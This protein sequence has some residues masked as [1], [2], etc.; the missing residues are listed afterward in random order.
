MRRHLIIFVCLIFY[1]IGLPSA[2]YAD[3]ANPPKIQKVTQ[4]TKGPYSPG[5]MI[6]FSIEVSGGNPGLTTIRIS[7]DCF[8][9]AWF[10]DPKDSYQIGSQG[11][12]D[13]S[14]INEKLITGRIGGCRSKTYTAS[15]TV[16]DKT[17]L[18]DGLSFRSNDLNFEIKNRFL[19]AVGEIQPDPDFMKLQ[20]QDDVSWAPYVN[21]G[22]E[23]TR[24]NNI[25]VSKVSEL[26]IL[27]GFSKLGQPIDWWVQQEINTN[28]QII[29]RFE[30]DVG[31]LKFLG[32]GKCIVYASVLF[33]GIR[34]NVGGSSRIEDGSGRY[35]FII[36]KKQVVTKNVIFVFRC[37]HPFLKQ[38]P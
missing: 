35:S 2:T 3:S 9:T 32:I 34:L 26:L 31:N 25:E 38:R 4:I 11:D 10:S 5:D 22:K 14:Y 18:S 15:I 30:G 12:F 37:P 1:F 20:S 29:R 23:R 27:P 17:L 24:V 21:E 19:P 8:N 6:Q 36:E 28:C 13:P 33:D 16:V 7:S